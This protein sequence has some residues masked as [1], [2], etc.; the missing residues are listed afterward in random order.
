MKF[1]TTLVSGCFL[2]ASLLKG[3]RT[4]I[5]DEAFLG[6]I[7]AEAAQN[8]P[9]LQSAESRVKAAGLDIAGS[10]LW[11]DPMVGIGFMAADQMMRADDGDIMV[12]FEQTFPK[13]GLYE[14]NLIKSEAMRRAEMEKARAAGIQSGVEAT[15]VAIELALSDEIVRLSSGEIAWLREMESN[16]R[17]LAL[18]PAATSIDSIRL[19]SEVARSEQSLDAA[20]RSRKGFE[21]KLNLVLGR[22]LGNSW[23]TLRLPVSSP[24]VPQAASEV[25]RIAY[26]NP[27]VRTLREMANASRAEVRIADRERQPA[28]SVGVD[29]ALYSGGD[30]RSTTL[31]VKMTIPW[32]NRDSNQARID[33]AQF[34]ADAA[35]A[36][37]EVLRREVATQVIT[38]VTEAANA[39]AQAR[40][41]GGEIRQKAIEA[42]QT[43]EASWIISK[44][45]L[46]DLLES[47]RL[48]FSVDLEQRRFIAMQ[49]AAVEKLNLLVPIQISK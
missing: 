27:Q 3:Q 4:N 39:A 24:P 25:A 43:L 18:D 44:A 12:G 1:L 42:N 13:P 10:R 49:L 28:I 36:D 29:T 41:Y 32:F 23:R 5:L 45:P 16:A 38:A 35:T 31:G 7:R 40:A 2:L 15:M 34:R 26:A 30:F 8:H 9:S 11:E 22:T 6:S 19:A 37:I 47:R 46:T 17:D 48:L 20:G 21:Q 33:A 14:A